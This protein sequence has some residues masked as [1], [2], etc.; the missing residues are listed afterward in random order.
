MNIQK[1]TLSAI[2]LMIATSTSAAFASGEHNEGHD[3]QAAIGQPADPAKADRTINIS[4]TEM[5]FSPSRIEVEDGETITFV[6][7]NDGRMVHEFNI[8]NLG[9]WKGHAGEMQKMM[10]SGMMTAM[11]LNHNKMMEGGMMH[12][13][14]NSVLLEAGQ[15][16]EVTWTF[17]AGG[18]VGFAC[19]VPGH[20]QGGMVGEVDIQEG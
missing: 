9:T 5:K 20:R 14:P 3:E 15:T 4:M 1:N 19:N 7:T 13:D 12:D 8:G 2:A 17:D 6:V 10:K 18:D 11:K 16:A